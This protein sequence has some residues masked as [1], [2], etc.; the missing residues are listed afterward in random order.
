MQNDRR[1][2]LNVL[3]ARNVNSIEDLQAL[4]GYSR[5]QLYRH[6]PAL[7]ENGRVCRKVGTGKVNKLPTALLPVIKQWLEQE[8]YLSCAKMCQRLL[9]DHQINISKRGLSWRLNKEKIKFRSQGSVPLLTEVHKQ[10][11]IQWCQQNLTRNFSNVIFSDESYFQLHR[12]KLKVWSATAINVPKP[13]KSPAV[14][15]WAAISTKGPVSIVIDTGTIN[16]ETYCGIICDNLIPSANI[17]FPDGWI[18]QQD[19]APAHT[20]QDTK[21]IMEDYNVNTIDWPARSP[22]LNIIENVW[23]Y[24]KS[25]IEKQSPSSLQ[26]LK[27]LILNSWNNLPVQYC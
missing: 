22:D 27:N 9:S 19:N 13:A 12:N 23:S 1:S 26:E 20:A 18:F 8:P 17:M 7:Q 24:M 5:A 10:N 3:W 21:S 6:R 25:D 2:A 11:R 15:V 4:T 16:S 14:M